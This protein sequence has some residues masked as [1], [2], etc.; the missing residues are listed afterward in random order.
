MNSQLE[1]LACSYV[2]DQLDPGDRAAFEARLLSEPELAS[3]VRQFE[4]A[5]AQNIR[6]L[7][8]SEPPAHVLARIESRLGDAARTDL[9]PVAARS[10]PFPWSSFLRWG[11][12]A[13]ITLSLGTLAVQSLR[14]PQ[15]L[16]VLVSL[17]PQHSTLTELPFPNTNKDPDARFIQLAS[18]A[19][20]FW[21]NPARLPVQPHASDRDNRGYALFDPASRQG[22]IAIKQLPA[23][24]SGQRYHLWIVDTASGSIRDAGMLPLSGATRGLYSFSLAATDA[25]AKS[26]QQNFFVT[27]ED[28]T[29]SPSAQPRGHV[30]L[31]A[32]RI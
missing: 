6:A 1:E 31:G 12:A 3:L 13:V 24:A 2:L 21:E 17:D 16:V 15:P 5:L 25:P 4:A 22:F 30:V 18:L 26:G 27:V 9:S 28:S 14:R 11:V 23:I 32:K 20:Q 19:E 7:P 10:H 8:P 29:T